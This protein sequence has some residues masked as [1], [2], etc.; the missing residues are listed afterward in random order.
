ML[1]V[2][3]QLE[4]YRIIYL[5]KIIHGVVPNYGIKWINTERRGIYL[6]IP[7]SNYK[8]TAMATRMRDQSLIVHGGRIYNLLPSDLR[9][10]MDKLDSF[11]EKLD[12]FLGQIPDH[13][14]SPGLT[15]VPIN[16]VSNRHSNSLYDWIKFKLSDR[17]MTKI[18]DDFI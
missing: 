4:R 12:I 5:W 6:E 1:S 8:H 18:D 7:K 11:K 10:C 17:K 2:Q 3:R 14:S 13:P 9:N 15:P 16:P